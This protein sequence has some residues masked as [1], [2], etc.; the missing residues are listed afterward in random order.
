MD[1][2]L[3]REIEQFMYREARILDERRFPEWL[4]LLTEDLHYWMPG[5]STRYPKESRALSILDRERYVEEEVSKENE[6]AILDETKDSLSRRIERLNTGM[7]WAED[8]PSRTRHIITNIEVEEV[9]ADSQL[10]VYSNF[11]MYR[12]RAETEQDFYVG[13]REDVLRKENGDWKIAYRKIVLDQN[14]LLAKNVSNF[15]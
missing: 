7:A 12:T 10:K 3:I 15:F 11:I 5:R 2:E 1:Q 6:L 13:R 4:E 9:E 8:P 14:V